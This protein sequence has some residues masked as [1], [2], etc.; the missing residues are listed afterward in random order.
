MYAFLNKN[1]QALAFGIGVLVV[2]IFMVSIF[3]ADGAEIEALTSDAVKGPEKYA[4]GVFD[5]GIFASIGLI[6]LAFAVAIIFG[7]TQLAS[8]PKGSLKGIIGFVALIVI[9]FICYQTANGDISQ[10]SQAIQNSINK[11]KA[12]Q[13]AAFDGGLLKFVGGSIIAAVALIAL[14]ILSLIAFG[15]RGIFK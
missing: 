6:I 10:E 3:S 9:C 1:G 12:D 14:S 7:I 8:N 5:F 13:G 15:I 11:F 2:L 4:T